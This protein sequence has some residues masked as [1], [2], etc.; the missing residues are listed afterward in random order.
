[1]GL[2]IAANARDD[3]MYDRSW[4]VNCKKLRVLILWAIL[5]KLNIY[6]HNV[7]FL[8][9]VILYHMW[10]PTNKGSNT[11]I[12]KWHCGNYKNNYYLIYSL[13]KLAVNLTLLVYSVQTNVKVTVTLY[14]KKCIQPVID[15]LKTLKQVLSRY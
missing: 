2:T 4:C 11:E 12:S 7:F 15:I 1:M 10:A 6:Y 3:K 8:Q 9:S 5:N 14:V 13:K